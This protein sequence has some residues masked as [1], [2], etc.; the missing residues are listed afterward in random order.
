MLEHHETCIAPALSMRDVLSTKSHDELS[1][2]ELIHRMETNRLLPRYVLTGG[3]AQADFGFFDFPENEASRA[4]SA[5]A[6]KQRCIDNIEKLHYGLCKIYGQHLSDARVSSRV[7]ADAIRWFLQVDE[8][9]PGWH[10]GTFG[11]YCRLVGREPR[12]LRD[13]IFRLARKRI[14]NNAVDES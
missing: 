6:S 12:E 4:F 8:P 9:E 1:D 7:R 2:Q 3:A 14:H 11:T 10:V 13:V 5:S